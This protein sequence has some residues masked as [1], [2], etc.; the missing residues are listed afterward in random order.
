MKA[1]R[2]RAKTFNSTSTPSSLEE[3]SRFKTRLQLLIQKKRHLNWTVSTEEEVAVHALWSR[4][5]RVESSL[6][7]LKA[8]ILATKEAS[9][10]ISVKT[11]LVPEQDDDMDSPKELL[12]V[13]RKAAIPRVVREG[14]NQ[15]DT[16]E[17]PSTA[18][19]ANPAVSLRKITAVRE[20]SFKSFQGPLI[21]VLPPTFRRRSAASSHVTQSLLSR[22]VHP[23]RHHRPEFC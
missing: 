11:S 10:L 21:L 19:P 2:L 22:L 13:P 8:A 1:G 9:E 4:I 23:P 14:L 15:F 16:K 18:G 5:K 12:Q 17:E 7:D 3:R 20:E 6:K